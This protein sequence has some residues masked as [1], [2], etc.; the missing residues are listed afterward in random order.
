M[1]HF[2]WLKGFIFPY[3][4]FFIFMFLAV[5]LFKKPLINAMAQRKTDFEQ[6]VKEANS[7][8]EIAEAKHAELSR[9]YAQLDEEIRR[10]K[11]EGE[12][13]ACQ[14]AADMLNKAES[15]ALHLREEAR[16]MADAELARA[17][18][19]LRTEI[20]AEAK[21]QTLKKLEVELDER[22][23]KD[24]AHKRITSLSLQG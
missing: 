14:R 15:L 20:I 19:A 11:A 16:R 10:M 12:A 23:Q 1:E 9:R 6:L 18:E 5:K 22:A 24:L 17:R 7:A 21:N 8:R 2:D 4:N 3:V 13:D